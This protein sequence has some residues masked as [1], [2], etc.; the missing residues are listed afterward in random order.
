[1][2][3]ERIYNIALDRFMEEKVKLMQRFKKFPKRLYYNQKD[4][5]YLLYELDST[6]AKQIWRN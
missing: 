2:T 5:E 3:N 4:K 6:L 1:M